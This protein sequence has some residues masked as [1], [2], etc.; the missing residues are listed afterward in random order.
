MLHEYEDKSIKIKL[1]D[2][3]LSTM[4]KDDAIMDSYIRGSG[5]YI[6]PAV[7]DNHISDKSLQHTILSIYDVWAGLITVFSIIFQTFPWINCNKK[8]GDITTFKAFK[9]GTPPKIVYEDPM[10]IMY[11]TEK[12]AH[13][14]NNIPINIRQFE[15]IFDKLSN[16]EYCLELIPNFSCETFINENTNLNI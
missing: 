12:Q 10:Y 2:F 15:I 7:S 14:K 13:W 6:G 16:D 4:I 8:T 9:L 11:I 1:I 3:G 5:Y